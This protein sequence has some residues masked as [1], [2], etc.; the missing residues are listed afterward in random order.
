MNSTRA[1]KSRDATSLHPAT[2]SLPFD[3]QLFPNRTLINC[4]IL[5]SPVDRVRVPV[6]QAKRVG[7]CG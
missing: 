6:N 3:P 7:G 4:G 2:K 1:I 5:N